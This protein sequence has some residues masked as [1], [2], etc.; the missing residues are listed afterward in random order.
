MGPNDNSPPTR[1]LKEPAAY[2]NLT[3]GNLARNLKHED[4]EVRLEAVQALAEMGPDAREAVPVLNNTLLTDPDWRVRGWSALA[5][6][7]IGPA[8]KESVPALLEAMNDP[9]REVR[10][11]AI[12]A[13][14]Y[15]NARRPAAPAAPL[16]WFSVT[17]LLDNVVV[18]ENRLAMP[19]ATSSM[20]GRCFRPVMPSAT[21][22]DSRLSTPPSRVNESA[23]G[24][25]SIT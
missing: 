23:A 8:A 7:R 18:A 4:P 20:L 17:M 14:P 21:L 9:N 2:E 11:A 25:S 1:Q 19:C 22:A 16:T 13:L 12:R 24:S 10:R 6:G 15:I 3:V 5:L